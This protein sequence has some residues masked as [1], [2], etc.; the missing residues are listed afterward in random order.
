MS[1]SPTPRLLLASILAGPS[2]V[3]FSLIGFWASQIPHPVTIEPV[4]L[5]AF[6]LFISLPLS[7]AIGLPVALVCNAIGSYLL[8]AIGSKFPLLRFPFLWPVAGGLAAWAA[9]RAMEFPPDFVFAF[10]AA[11]AVSAL[12]CRMRLNGSPPLTRYVTY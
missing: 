6:L 8:V 2:V 9:T 10:S 7:S 11:G 5:L 3:L 1:E 4:S 12:I